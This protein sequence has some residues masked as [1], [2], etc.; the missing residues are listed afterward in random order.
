[1]G[2]FP[3][4][5][6]SILTEEEKVRHIQF[7]DSLQPHPKSLF[8]PVYDRRGLRLAIVLGN[9][10]PSGMCPYAAGNNC[11]HCDIG[12]GEGYRFDP[13]MNLARFRWLKK[14]YSSIWPSVA[15][16][17][18]YNSGSVLNRI[19]LAPEI[20]T[21]VLHFA[22]SLPELRVVS[23]E[24]REAFVTPEAVS[25]LT[26]DLGAGR[27]VRVIV[28]IESADDTIR[29]KLLR[30]QMPRRAIE[31]AVRAISTV[32]RVV[33]S[34]GSKAALPGLTTNVIVGGPGTTTRSIVRDAVE[35]SM[36]SLRLAQ[37]YDLPLDL[38]LHPYYPS[39][40]SSARFP[41]HTRPSL[42]AL[43]EAVCAVAQSVGNGAPVF[44][45]L[46]DEGHDQDPWDKTEQVTRFAR[47]VDYFN[48]T[49]RLDLFR[50]L[51]QFR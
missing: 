11:H 26:A 17:V 20:L 2:Q 21:A 36:Y 49:G 34:K 42:Q 15:H 37:A 8:R 1:M 24:S 35:T 12:L 33:A 22:R 38:N 45:G 28:G 29:N 30:K 18:V 43:V 3:A 9:E 23:L 40:R 50:D 25:R 41:D 48:R 46:E 31:R 27:E 16:L 47:A 13:A 32:R 7:D 14:H 10:A 39:K 19:E 6:A 51:L 4:T 5:M 44:V